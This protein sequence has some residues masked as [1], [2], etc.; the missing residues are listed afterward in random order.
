M[1]ERRYSIKF[2]VEIKRLYPQ[3]LEAV[4][5]LEQ[6]SKPVERRRQL[7]EEAEEERQPSREE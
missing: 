3:L 7:T 6:L 5:S 1:E 4:W 2:S